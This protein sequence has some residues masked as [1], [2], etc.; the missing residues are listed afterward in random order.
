M[1]TE[2]TKICKGCGNELSIS[3]FGLNKNRM[4]DGHLNFCKKCNRVKAARWRNSLGKEKRKEINEKNYMWLKAH[5]G[6]H[7]NQLKK[8]Y[9]KYPLRK[10]AHFIFR[11]ALKNNKLSKGNCS[12]CG[13]ADVEAHHPDYSKPLEVIWLC[14]KHHGLLRRRKA[15]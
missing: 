7:G 2:L 10:K 1:T 15:I 11:T 13:C 8:Y 5:P 4:K 14:P 6:Y 3:N 9:S 12:V